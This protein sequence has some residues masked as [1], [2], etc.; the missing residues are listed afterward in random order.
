MAERA[1][2]VEEDGPVAAALQG[3]LEAAGFAVDRAAPGDALH[4]L[5]TDHA[6]AVVRAER[7]ELA[8]ALKARDPTLPVLALHRDDDAL[9]AAGDGGGAVDGVLVGPLLRPAV[10]SAARA[11]SRLAGHARRIADLERG[12]APGREAFE[13]HRRLVLLE[14]KRARRYRYPVA[15]V[16]VSIDDWGDVASSLEGPAREELLGEVLSIVARS[17]RSVDLPVLH[18]GERFLVVLPHT[19]GEGALIL[20]SRLCA[21]VGARPGPPRVTASAGV[22]SFEGTGQVSLGSL[23]AD[24]SRGLERARV[25]GG[26]RAERGT[27]GVADRKVDLGW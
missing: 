14:V 25:A 8:R 13:L 6:L 22:A 23:V 21:Q 15:L 5:R 18:S 12:T 9:L 20:A 27:G 11:M 7:P 17:L 19:A 26:G 24:A 2:I 3:H 16:L 4:L 1:L 10:T